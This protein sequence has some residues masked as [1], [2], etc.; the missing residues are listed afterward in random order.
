MIC[1]QCETEYRDGFT[2]C[3]DCDV[4]LIEPRPAV[5]VAETRDDVEQIATFLYLHQAELAASV[6]EGSD[7]E[8]F[9]G[10]AFF[11]GVRPELAFTSG[12]IKLFVRA[13]DAERAREVLAELDESATESD[14]SS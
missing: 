10:D 7:I 9:L 12:G 6:L 5:N 4:D 14:T 2:R 8:C 1:P 13:G 11:A 3:S